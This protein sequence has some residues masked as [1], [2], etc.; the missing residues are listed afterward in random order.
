MIELVGNCA[1][2]HSSYRSDRA[3][4]GRKPAG[5]DKVET[6]LRTNQGKCRR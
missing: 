6:K 1:Q 4:H 2:K 3:K 5:G